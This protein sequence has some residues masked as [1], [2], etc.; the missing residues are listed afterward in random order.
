[1]PESLTVVRAR[2]IERW[3]IAPRIPVAPGALRR[4][5]PFRF[6]WQTPSSP[7]AV[8]GCL[9]PTDPGHWPVRELFL[10]PPILRVAEAAEPCHPVF[11]CFV[12]TLLHELCELLHRH[13]KAPDPE[14]TQLHF[15]DRRFKTGGLRI[16]VRV[17]FLPP[18]RAHQETPR[19]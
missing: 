15:M 18:L 6:R 10:R 7:G 19:G 1:M 8:R 13:R 2:S 3:L 4:P 11:P 5:L 9:E 14:P 12:T 17:S 16:V